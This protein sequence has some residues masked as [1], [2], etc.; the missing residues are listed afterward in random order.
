MSLVIFQALQNFSS[1]TITS[2]MKYCEL[3]WCFFFLPLNF[4]FL[5]LPLYN[6]IMVNLSEFVKK[7]QD[8]KTEDQSKKKKK[9]RKW[10]VV[11]RFAW[12]VYFDLSTFSNNKF[13]ITLYFENSILINNFIFIMSKSV[14]WEI[15]E[16]L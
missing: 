1:T 8:L 9:H 7:W 2:D 16:N 12:K 15:L 3:R 5:I 14:V 13:L 6:H 11:S 10:M 4:L